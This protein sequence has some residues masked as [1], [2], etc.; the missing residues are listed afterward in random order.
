[1]RPFLVTHEIFRRPAFGRHHPLATGRQAAVQDL[2]EVLGWR[3][4]ALTRVPELPGRAVLERFHEPEYLSALEQADAAGRATAE[5]R[6]RYN[7]GT[8]ECPVFPGL[9]D[10]ARA[11]V[12]GSMLAAELVLG[13]GMAFHP[14]GGTHHGMPGRAS[15]FCYLNDPAFAVLRLLDGGLARVLHVDLDA[16][17]GDG[18]EAAFA[19]DPR[20]Y[21]ASLHEDGRWP[22]TGRPGDTLGGRALNVPVPRG[23]HDSEYALVLERLV[24]PFVRRAEPEAIVVLL[25]ADGLA[26]DPLS[27][28]Q[29]S[30][31]V[32]WRACR[33]LAAMA[34]RAVVL[35]GGG[36]NPWTTA[37]LW[38]G[39]WGLLAGHDISSELPPSAQT[40]LA[41]LDC[42]LVDD[43]DRDPAWLTTLADAPNVGPIRPEVGALIAGH[44]M[45][46]APSIA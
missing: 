12:G 3:D 31:D 33:T 45:M 25:G 24:Y 20:V 10:R 4:P 30:N 18:V 34:P 16:H 44:P 37:R 6:E 23:I 36:Y 27:G 43:E 9:W 13:G 19:D 40:V 21:M 42:D 41:G 14:T 26:G 32:L 38:A 17:H 29:L 46:R 1:M 39:M 28:M 15:G 7:L 8:M 22:G 5:M 11:T 35:G 2:I